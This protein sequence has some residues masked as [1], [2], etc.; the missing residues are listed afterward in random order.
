MPHQLK[1]KFEQRDKNLHFVMK[2]YKILN[3]FDVS[4]FTKNC[5]IHNVPFSKK[6]LTN[7]ICHD[8]FCKHNKKTLLTTLS[9][10]LDDLF[11][12][13]FYFSNEQLCTL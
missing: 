11:A 7:Y 3:S 10:K 8:Q 2:R 6:N 1:R 9:E 12:K 13:N 4:N 5:E